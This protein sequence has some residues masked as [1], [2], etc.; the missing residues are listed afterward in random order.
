L[1]RFGFH[2]LSHAAIARRFPEGRLISAHLGGGC[3]LAVI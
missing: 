3:S 2:E 1:H